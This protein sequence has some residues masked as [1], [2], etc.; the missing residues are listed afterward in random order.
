MTSAVRHNSTLST[1]GADAAMPGLTLAQTQ[2]V[3]AL[4]AGRSVTAAARQAGTHRSTVHN[5]LKSNSA[6]AAAVREAREDYRHILTD[7]LLDLASQALQTVQEILNS[8]ET[9]ASVRLRAALAILERPT[10]PDT[11]WNLPASVESA[12]ESP[13]I[14]EAGA[15]SDSAIARSAPCPCG[16][17]L[18][19]KRCCGRTAPPALNVGQGVVPGVGV[20]PTCPVK[21]AGF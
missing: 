19:Y 15:H 3:Q 17:G 8:P 12:A 6:F 13:Q 7:G 18:K 4:A 16:S 10:S 20:E 1:P 5:W 21:G 14:E 2:V 11:G 9:P